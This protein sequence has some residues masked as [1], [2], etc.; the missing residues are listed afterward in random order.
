M[1]NADF[2]RELKPEFIKEIEWTQKHGKFIKTKSF[3]EEFHVDI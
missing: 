3:S 1:K 2:E